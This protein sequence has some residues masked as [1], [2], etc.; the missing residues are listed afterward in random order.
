M[1]RPPTNE[2][3]RRAL[4]SAALT[5]VFVAATIVMLRPT[6]H[7]LATRIQ[8]NTGD[9]A[10]LTWILAWGAHALVHQPAHLFDANMFWPWGHT[11]AYSDTLLPLAPV[12]AAIRAVVPDWTWAIGLLTIGLYVLCLWSTFLLARRL[13]GDPYAAV[14][15]ALAFTFSSFL[16]TEWSHLQLQTVGL[17]PLCYLA[18]F[19]TLDR[20]S[21]MR[22]ALFGGLSGAVLLC[23][24]YYGVVYPVTVVAMLGLGVALRWV[25]IDR[26]LVMAGVAAAVGAGVIGG[27]ATAQYLHLQ[28]AFGFRRNYEPQ[29]S[30]HVS[31]LLSPV[32]GSFVWRGLANHVAVRNQEHHFFPGLVTPALG[33]AGAGQL[34]A[35]LRRR[36][37]DQRDR[38]LLLMVVAGVIGLVLALG[39]TIAGHAGPFRFFHNHVPG[40]SGIRVTARFAAFP[41]LVASLLAARGFSWLTRRLAD[42][43]SRNRLAALLLPGAAAVVSGLLLVDLAARLPWAPL[44]DNGPTVEVYQT[45]AHAGR[46]A[47]VELPMIDPRVQPLQWAF[48]E[49]PRMVYSTVDW[50]ARVNGYSAFVP[51]TYYS[52]VTLFATFPSA[53]AVDRAR[54]LGVRWVI[55]HVGQE[56]GFPVMSEAAAQAVVAG[57]PPGATARREGTAWLIDLGPVSR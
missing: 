44:P 53:P 4:R 57:L 40:F 37:L 30:L 10:L 32:Q 35:S 26:A 23:A 54:A 46:G 8:G 13:T 22:G 21:L 34:G 56:F 36:P 20:P 15:G 39:P 41:F 28:H 51:P 27:A 48:I 50:H 12:Y 7:I 19:W 49:A 9:P 1:P 45:L 6:P 11:L 55:V 2:L 17:L 43:Q 18:L 33:L 25:R 5:V 42:P 31:D 14:V 47:V 29:G 16:T 38:E 52:D 24:V 3:T